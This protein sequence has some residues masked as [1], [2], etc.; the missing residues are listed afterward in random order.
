MLVRNGLACQLQTTPT[1]RR[2]TGLDEFQA[3]GKAPSHRGRFQ[4]MKNPG[5]E[6]NIF[7]SHHICSKIKIRTFNM[8]V[9]SIFIFNTETSYHP[10]EM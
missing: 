5:H 10:E 3:T 1:E 4:K 8:Y 7:A 9:S 6:H 2:D